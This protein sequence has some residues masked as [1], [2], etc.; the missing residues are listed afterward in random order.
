ME[1]GNQLNQL[2]DI[3]RLLWGFSFNLENSK[4]SLYLIKPIFERRPYL[5]RETALRGSGS[6]LLTLKRSQNF[7]YSTKVSIE[8]FCPLSCKTDVTG[9]RS[10]IRVVKSFSIVSFAVISVSVVCLRF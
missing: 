1:D 9:W 6:I 8:D 2:G 3:K 7:K 4:K 10:V 5:E